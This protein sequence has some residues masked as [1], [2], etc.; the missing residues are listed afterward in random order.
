MNPLVAAG[1]KAVAKIVMKEGLDGTIRLLKQVEATNLKSPRVH[2]A[3][4]ILE[5]L[6]TRYRGDGPAGKR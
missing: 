6:R 2:Q 1:V 5:Q 3:R 4:R